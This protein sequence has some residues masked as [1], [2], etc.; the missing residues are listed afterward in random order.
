MMKAQAQQA[1]MAPGTGLLQ[2]AFMLWMCGS[3]IGIFSIMM[4]ANALMGPIKAL[5]SVNQYFSKFE[6]EEGMDL[7]NPKL[8]YI[9]IQIVGLA[10]GLYKC[11]TL[12]LLPLTSADWTSLIPLKV[13]KEYSGI[14]I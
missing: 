6:K 9:G 12:G 10:M 4:T 13:Y 8:M 1:A 11:S 3:A 5:L 2:T 14:P 7:T